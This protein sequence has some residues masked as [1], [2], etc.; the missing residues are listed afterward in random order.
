MRCLV[1]L[2]LV[3]SAILHGTQGRLFSGGS[4]RRRQGNGRM[5]YDWRSIDFWS[6]RAV[7]WTDWMYFTLVVFG[8]S[9][10]AFYADCRTPDGSYGYCTRLPECGSLANLMVLPSPATLNFIRK[11]I[12]GYQGFEPRV[13]NSIFTFLFFL[14]LFS[15]VRVSISHSF[16]FFDAR[17]LSATSSEAS[18]DHSLIS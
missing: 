5:I 6:H 3:V 10:T 18:A 9:D 1:Y 13:T 16:R 2:L 8:G 11:S 4:R 7:N 12:C 15:L 14:F 17:I